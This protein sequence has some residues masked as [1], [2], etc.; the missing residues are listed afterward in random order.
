MLLC[1]VRLESVN[2][3]VQN[4]NFQSKIDEIT[5]G[6][7][8]ATS[9]NFQRQ[10]AKASVFLCTYISGRLCKKGYRFQAVAQ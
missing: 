5:L 9:E 10:A 4:C 8:W 1:E 3:N 6:N 2:D 7:T